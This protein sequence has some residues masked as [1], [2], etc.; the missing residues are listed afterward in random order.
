M[1]CIHTYCSI[2]VIVAIIRCV[3]SKYPCGWESRLS[4]SRMNWQLVER[5]KR[6]QQQQPNETGNSDAHTTH[7]S[8]LSKWITAPRR[9][10]ICG[11]RHYYWRDPTLQ[12]KTLKHVQVVS[13]SDQLVDKS[14]RFD[15]KPRHAHTYGLSYTDVWNWVS[16]A[17]YVR[18]N[19]V[20]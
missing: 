11:Q 9:F 13:K 10:E 7:E 4:I 12:L 17:I 5:T 6:Q 3:A 14:P 19:I 2:V 20:V 8:V 15:N 16:T 1:L 18:Y